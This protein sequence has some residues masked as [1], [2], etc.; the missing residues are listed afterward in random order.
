M[1]DLEVDHGAEGDGAARDEL[2][3]AHHEARVHQEHGAHAEVPRVLEE[4]VTHVIYHKIG[5]YDMI[6]L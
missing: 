1:G 4:L 6:S 2:G 5:V 3:A